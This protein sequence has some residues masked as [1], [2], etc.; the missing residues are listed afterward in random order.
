MAKKRYINPSFPFTNSE[1]GHFVKLTRTDSEAIKSDILHILLTNKGERLYLPDFGTNLRKYLFEPQ[2]NTT[3]NEIR[4]E[5]R[6][7]VTRYI[8][9]LKIDNIEIDSPDTQNHLAKIRMDY[10]LTDDVFESKDFVEVNI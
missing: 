1:E 3:F 10:T 7:E 6:E 8:P 9:N 2:D 5:I 4:R